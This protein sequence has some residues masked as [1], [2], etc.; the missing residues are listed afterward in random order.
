MRNVI[1]AVSGLKKGDR[2]VTNLTFNDGKKPLY[3]EYLED[4]NHGILVNI[5]W[6][7]PYMGREPREYRRVLNWDSIFCG[8]IRVETEDGRRILAEQLNPKYRIGNDW[9][10]YRLAES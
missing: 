4:L 10:L 2:V 7:K 5:V 1:W 8:S 3:I 9:K 6:P